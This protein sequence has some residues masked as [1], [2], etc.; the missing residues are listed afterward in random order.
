MPRWTYTPDPPTTRRRRF[1]VNV[2]LNSSPPTRAE[3]VESLPLKR[4]KP[5][6]VPEPVTPQPAR[7]QVPEPQVQKP[8]LVPAPRKKVPKWIIQVRQLEL[9]ELAELLGLKVGDNHIRPCPCCGIE[10]GAELYRNKTGWLLWRCHACEIRDRGNVDLAS[11]ALAGEKA[12]DL[13]PER[14]AMLRRWFADQGLCD[15]VDG[16]GVNRARER[17]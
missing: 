2:P 1:P 15:A 8:Q 17:E 7:S 6:T 4:P 16:D 13:G 5:T 3:V 14:K 11:Y 10:S 12:G 9:V